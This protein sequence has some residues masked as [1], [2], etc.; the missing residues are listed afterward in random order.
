[1]TFA[2]HVRGGT[3]AGTKSQCQ[4]AP[5]THDCSGVWLKA[6]EKSLTKGR[7]M[8]PADTPH[9]VTLTTYSCADCGARRPY[10][11]R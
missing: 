2:V 1:M 3:G 11:P 4:P 7:A 6:Y 10:A 9:P 8:F 5:W